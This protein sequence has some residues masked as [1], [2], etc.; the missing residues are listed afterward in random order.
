MVSY[1][2][3]LIHN[4]YDFLCEWIEFDI[5]LESLLLKYVN[6]R[7]FLTMLREMDIKCQIERLEM[8]LDFV[9]NDESEQTFNMF[10]RCLIDNNQPHV[11]AEW[12]TLK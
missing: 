6:F 1:W 2:H 5:G 4:N 11:V 12:L 9:G 7:D 8:L 10:R 3:N